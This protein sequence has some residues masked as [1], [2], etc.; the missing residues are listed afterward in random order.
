[1]GNRG[2]SFVRTLPGMEVLLNAL[3]E[4]R[5]AALMGR[6]MEAQTSFAGRSLPPHGG[7]PG[8]E[9]LAFWE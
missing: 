3:V 5:A 7:A 1:M 6:F 8:R 9:P 2:F 4:A